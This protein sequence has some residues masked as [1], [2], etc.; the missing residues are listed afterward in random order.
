MKNKIILFGIV[1]AVIFGGC[2]KD[3]DED[4]QVGDA[5]IEGWWDIEKMK[6]GN[7]WSNSPTELDKDFVLF[8]VEHYCLVDGETSMIYKKDG[9]S[10][11][12]YDASNYTKLLFN[13]E[14]LSQ[15][16]SSMDVRMT[17]PRSDVVRE[18]RL[19]RNNEKILFVK[20]PKTYI[21]GTWRVMDN[22][23][24]QRIVFNDSKVQFYD[25]DGK[26]V[27]EYYYFRHKKSPLVINLDKIPE[28]EKPPII[29][30]F[31][32]YWIYIE[33]ITPYRRPNTFRL[34]QKYPESKSFVCERD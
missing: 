9:N 10:I 11:G 25:Y 1:L 17:S 31:V 24:F 30:Y 14:I 28:S 23:K 7:K 3:S 19:R 18:Y 27:N 34:V 33:S 21:K 32:D 6:I 12:C 5:G 8:T 29:G 15:S 13:F 22:D 20:D 2:S 26:S 16:S 4:E